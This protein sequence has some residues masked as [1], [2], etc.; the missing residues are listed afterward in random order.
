MNEDAARKAVKAF[1][2]DNMSTFISG[3]SIQGNTINTPHA[4]RSEFAQPSGTGANQYPFIQVTCRRA[5]L[6]NITPGGNVFHIVGRYDMEVRVVD[7]AVEDRDDDTPYETADA[8]FRTMCDRMVNTLL[9][10]ASFSSGSNNFSLVVTNPENLVGKENVDSW[11][12]RRGGPVQA[13][14]L[15][16]RL[17]FTVE[18]C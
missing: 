2:D 3:L 4:A 9:T 1:M 13:L 18:D 8:N 15:G 6:A 5:R 16:A 12:R 14:I 10:T 17:T 7:L 11:L